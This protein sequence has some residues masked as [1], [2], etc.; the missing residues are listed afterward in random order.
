MEAEDCRSIVQQHSKREPQGRSDRE[1]QQPTTW[2][3]SKIWQ[4]KVCVNT[5]FEKGLMEE[6]RQNCSKLI[7]YMDTALPH[8][9]KPIDTSFNRVTGSFGSHQGIYFVCNPCP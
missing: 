8:K 7:H 3:C 4:E 6:I 5:D 9:K 1:P 2:K